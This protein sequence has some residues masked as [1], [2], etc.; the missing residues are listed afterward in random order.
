MRKTNKAKAVKATTKTVSDD[1]L[2]GTKAEMWDNYVPF[3][4]DDDKSIPK[5]TPLIDS[6]EKEFTLKKLTNGRY[7]L[8]V[9]YSFM[10]C[11]M[12]V[13][14]LLTHV[15]KLRKQTKYKDILV[16]TDSYS[17]RD[18]LIKV[19]RFKRPFKIY[20]L[21]ETRL[22]LSIENK[23]FPFMFVLTPDMRVT[24]IFVPIKEYSAQI[25]EYL[26]Y[27]NEYISNANSSIK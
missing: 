24:K 22:G 1:F 19:T 14:T 23:N 15:E 5:E 10:D 27:T 20:N 7:T 12:C 21:P 9:R 11:E 16:I 6:L 25:D 4:Y 18:Y 26:N 2:N 13:D 3:M 8:I 17:E